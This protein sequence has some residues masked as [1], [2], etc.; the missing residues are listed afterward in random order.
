MRWTTVL[1]SIS[2]ALLTFSLAQRRSVRVK[3]KGVPEYFKALKSRKDQDH[4]TKAVLRNGL[5]V[6]I[7][8]RASHSLA[9]VVTY[10][11]AGYFQQEDA[12]LG[13]AELVGRLSIKHTTKRGAGEVAP[14]V[15]LLGGSLT[16]GTTQDRTCYYGVVPMENVGKMLEIQADVLLRPSFSEPRIAKERAA[17]LDDSR[18]QLHVPLTFA[19]RRLLELVYRKHRMRRWPLGNE[20]TLSKINA[21]KL[22]G[23]HQ[24]HYRPENVIL[25][26]SGAVRR[27]RILEKIVE[28]Y[29]SMKP[30]TKKASSTPG[31]TEPSDSSFRYQHLRGT[32]QQAYGLLAYRVPGVSHD[33]Y[34]PLLLLSY[35]LG[36]G[37]GS[38]LSQYLVQ[39]GTALETRCRL[40]AFRGGGAFFIRFTSEPGQAGHAERQILAQLEVLRQQGIDGS[41]L[42]RAKALFLREFYEVLE[43]VDQ[44]AYWL[45]H[46]EA[47][48]SYLDRE[49]LPGKIQEVGVEK[50]SRV[51]KRYFKESALSLV[52]HFPEEAEVRTFTAASFLEAMRLLVPAEVRKRRADLEAYYAALQESGFELPELQPSYLTS[53]LKRTSILR[54]PEIF[55]KEEHSVPLVHIGFFFP[56]GRAGESQVNAGITELT[57][58]TLLHSSEEAEG[59]LLWGYLEGLGAEVEIINEPDFFGLQASVLSPHLE[60]ILPILIQWARKPLLKE[61]SVELERKQMLGLIQQKKEDAFL[62]LLEQANHAIFEDHPYGLARYG[63]EKS[64]SNITLDWIQNWVDRQMADVH[65]LIVLRGDVKGT[66]FLQG[67]V[68]ALSDS[69]AEKRKLIRKEMGEVKE[70]E[71]RSQSFRSSLGDGV[72]RSA[73][74]LSFP[75]PA[76]ATR[77]DLVLQVIE[78]VL[79]G[80]GGRLAV[81][82]R[83]EQ[84]VAYEVKLFHKAGASG[85]AIFAYLST[86]PESEEKARQGLFRELSQLKRIPLR[87]DELLSALTATIGSFYIQQQRGGDYVLELTRNILTGEGSDYRRTNYESEYISAIKNITRE[88]VLSFAREYFP[89]AEDSESQVSA[90]PGQAGDS[91]P[92][93]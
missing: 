27:E 73:L 23:F 75:G 80:A 21:E 57:L 5:T 12:V 89:K 79:T 76:K 69:R 34:Y 78:K 62:H 88:D 19:R 81:S 8:E 45:A 25:A 28:L 18:L 39:E 36:R 85:G 1:C 93:T 83:D 58:R 30:S 64:L 41:D 15:R 44:Q 47:L 70:A 86:S 49:T 91:G 50:V 66:S 26:V 10:V 72:Q 46:H 67:F 20:E 33:D 11:K 31:L 65:P 60:R 22:A 77:D 2:I 74:V 3:S 24:A 6:L 87:E 68:S 16:A 56:G 53:D 43:S 52:E 71:T 55:F 14:R 4:F 92:E 37:R 48:G 40:D 38:L 7:E 9:A 32:S 90:P 29:A 13:I 59:G 35:I 82:L 51:V 42:D 84:S 54:G 63:T 61:S 17:L